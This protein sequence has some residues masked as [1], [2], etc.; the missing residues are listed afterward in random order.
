[1]QETVVFSGYAIDGVKYDLG[2]TTTYRYNFVGGAYGSMLAYEGQRHHIPSDSVSTVTT[3]SGPAIRMLKEDHRM[4]ASCGGSTAAKNF[5]A[6]EEALI[7]AGKFDEAMQLGIDD[8]RSLFGS[9]YNRAIEQMISYA[10]KQGYIKA[11]A[12]K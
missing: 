8:V 12:V 6:K 5:R 10:V 3:Y 4:T 2:S 9:K 11:G 1:M 7:N